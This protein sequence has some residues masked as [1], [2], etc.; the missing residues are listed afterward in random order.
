MAG[1]LVARG[2]V[3]VAASNQ[4]RLHDS[5]PST[6]WIDPNSERPPLGLSLMIIHLLHNRTLQL[7][8]AHTHFEV[9][10]PS[11]PPPPFP[12]AAALSFSWAPRAARRSASLLCHLTHWTPDTARWQLQG[13]CAKRT[14][15]QR[16]IASNTDTHHLVALIFRQWSRVLCQL[17]FSRWGQR[18]TLSASHIRRK[19]RPPN[20]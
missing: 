20:P 8:W 19:S 18:E 10:A 5:S 6:S 1:A 3:F 4:W 12:R 11:H 9:T 13:G 7:S 15:Q 14:F 17:T 16:T 2:R